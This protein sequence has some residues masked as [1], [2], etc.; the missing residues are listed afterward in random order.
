LPFDIEALHPESGSRKDRETIDRWTK[1]NGGEARVRMKL[2]WQSLAFA[3]V[4]IGTFI[5]LDMTGV[6][7]GTSDNMGIVLMTGAAVAFWIVM[8]RRQSK[9]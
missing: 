4:L 2:F 1:A 7:R 6:T 9:P 3:F 8:Y 5:A